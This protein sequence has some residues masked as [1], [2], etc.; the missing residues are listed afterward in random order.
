MGQSNKLIAFSDLLKSSPKMAKH[1]GVI[2]GGNG[3][4]GF[5]VAVARCASTVDRAPVIARIA[6]SRGAVPKFATCTPG[7]EQ[8][9]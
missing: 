8:T 3:K 6:G 9:G 1:I 7:A 2:I 4:S 5:S